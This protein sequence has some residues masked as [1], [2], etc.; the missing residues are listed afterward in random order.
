[1][2]KNQNKKLA[3]LRSKSAILIATEDAAIGIACYSEV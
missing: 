2:E 1:M 3:V